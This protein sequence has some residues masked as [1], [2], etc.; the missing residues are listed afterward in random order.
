MHKIEFLPTLVWIFKDLPCTKYL[1]EDIYLVN[2]Q[3][4]LT[5]GDNGLIIFFSHDKTIYSANSQFRN[6]LPLMCGPM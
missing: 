6:S 3:L 2:G 4:V 5:R 1:E